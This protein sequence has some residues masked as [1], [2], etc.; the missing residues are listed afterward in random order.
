MGNDHMDWLIVAPQK[1]MDQQVEHIT[2]SNKR[3]ES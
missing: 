1:I 3:G 2:E